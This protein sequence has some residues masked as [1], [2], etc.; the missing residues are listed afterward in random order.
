M[1][2]RLRKRKKIRG[3]DDPRGAQM[4]YTFAA[5][6]R[7]VLKTLRERLPGEIYRHIAGMGK[8]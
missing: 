3:D 1:K 4:R 6:K 2:K 5:F 7:E 8:D